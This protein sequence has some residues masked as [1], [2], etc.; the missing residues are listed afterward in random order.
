MF[1]DTVENLASQAIERQPRFPD[2]VIA[3]PFQYQVDFNAGTVT[4]TDTGQPIESHLGQSD[5][6]Q[7]QISLAT[8]RIRDILLDPAAYNFHGALA[9]AWISP[10]QPG[11]YAE[12]RVTVGLSTYDPATET[13]QVKNYSGLFVDL[14]SPDCCDL[15]QRLSGATSFPNSRVVR[16]TPI[17]ITLPDD[18]ADPW[19][20]LSGFFPHHPQLWENISTGVVDRDYAALKDTIAPY[21]VAHLGIPLQEAER[22]LESQVGYRLIAAPNDCKYSLA[23]P[24][25]GTE[26]KLVKNCGQ[27]NAHIDAYICKGFKCKSCGGVYEGC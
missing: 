7:T 14:S 17:A 20:Y 18:V 6:I 11:L 22:W 19:D 2:A 15:A 1:V 3:T 26:Y 27:C 9:Y 4:S 23:T 8:L 21:A 10:P 5:Y 16:E 12:S 13:A 24:T 25:I